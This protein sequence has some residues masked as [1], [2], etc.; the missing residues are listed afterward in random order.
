MQKLLNIVKLK[1]MFRAQNKMGSTNQSPFYKKAEE[2]FLAA[3]TS[4]EKLEALEEMIRE[5][6]KHKSSEK[7]LAQLRLRYKKLKQQSEKSKKSGKHSKA[8][9]K[10][11]DMQAVII[12]KTNS[13]KSTLL[14]HLTNA[15][16]KTLNTKF[17]TTSPVIGMMDYQ[18]ANIQ[19]IEIPAIE[20]EYYDKGLVNSADTILT[21]INSLDELKDI[22]TKLN[23]SFGKGKRIIIYNSKNHR[24]NLRKISETF[25]S[26]KYD[27]IILSNLLRGGRGDGSGLEILKEKLF[28]SFDKIRVYTKEPGKEKSN[29]PI[30]LKPN[31]TVKQVAEKILHGFSNKVRET[32]IWGPSSKFAGQKIGLQHKL[33]DLDVVEFKTR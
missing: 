9:I 26:K 13:G 6:P 27:F 28:K 33:K 22:E 12:G 1:D 32:K 4:D 29:R 10:K 16:P 21:L 31:S 8:G 2:K 30:I 25:K 18:G 7:M 5:C 11:E 19:L 15:R 14:S 20:S 3:N 23:K 24:D 17:T